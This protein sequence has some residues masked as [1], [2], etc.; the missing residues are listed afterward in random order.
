MMEAGAGRPSSVVGSRDHDLGSGRNDA[1]QRPIR[2]GVRGAVAGVGG[3]TEKDS[4][5]DAGGGRDGLVPVGGSRG[6]VDVGG[7]GDLGGAGVLVVVDRG[8]VGLGGGLGGSRGADPRD[9]RGDG[10]MGRR[11][12]LPEVGDDDGELCVVAGR[13]G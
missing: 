11:G 7:V 12:G 6:A 2:V 4:G 10:G 1:A 8:R 5:G 3:L 13:G 9:H